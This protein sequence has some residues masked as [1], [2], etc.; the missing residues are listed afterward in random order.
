M[1]RIVKISVIRSEHLPVAVAARS[2]DRAHEF[3]GKH[4][5]DKAYGSYEK[6]AKDPD[7]EIVYIGVTSPY[8]L[9]VV[10]PM[11]NAGMKI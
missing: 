4:K 1:T 3:A 10:K 7:V 9:E 8:H 11:L 5:I 6:L 2:L